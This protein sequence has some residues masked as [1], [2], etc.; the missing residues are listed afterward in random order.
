MKILVNVFHPN[1]KDSKIN[2][3]M[4]SALNGQKN[5]TV[6]DV[7][8]EYGSLKFTD[9]IPLEKEKKLLKEH[10][11]IVFQHPIYWYS[12]PP[13]MKK[14]IEDILLDDWAW[15][16]NGTDLKGKEW[17]HAVSCAGDLNSYRPGDFNGFSLGEYLRPFQQTSVLC[18]MK[19]CPTFAIH[20]VYQLSDDALKK[21]TRNYLKFLTT[22]KLIREY[23]A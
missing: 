1:L 9:T 19:F 4:M 15:G 18:G 3:A 5:I 12:C 2:K 10:D 7:Y 16:K 11:R 21:T 8:K 6:R 23:E 20:H 22:K 14:W 13:L 17:V